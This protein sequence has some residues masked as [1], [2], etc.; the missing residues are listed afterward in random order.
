MKS[1]SEGRTEREVMRQVIDAARALGLDMERENVGVGVNPKGQ[2]VR[3]GRVGRPDLSCILPD[4]RLCRVEVKRE[5]YEPSKLRGK[6]REHF[7]RQL[8]EMKRINESNGVAFWVDDAVE[9]LTIMRFILQGY[10]VIED[11]YSRLHLVHGL[12]DDC[13]GYA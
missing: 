5:G 9:F 1:R 8:A 3:F 11:G 12:Y 6:A 2:Q 7:E 10:R 4:G 13:G